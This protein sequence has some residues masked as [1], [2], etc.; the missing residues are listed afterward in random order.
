[1]I[2]E[3]NLFEYEARGNERVISRVADK[4]SWRAIKETLIHNV[5]MSSVPVIKIEDADYNSN[6]VLLIK[7]YHEG[8]DLHLEY[9]EK[10]LQYLHQLWK[11]EVILETII[12]EKKSLLCFTDERLVIKGLR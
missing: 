2:R 9:A 8:R 6:R 10:T 1:L 4:E 5:G 11:R 3:M 7:H 12:N